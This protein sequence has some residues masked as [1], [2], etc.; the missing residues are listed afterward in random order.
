[1]NNYYFL[2]LYKL[3]EITPHSAVPAPCSVYS[4]ENPTPDALPDMDHDPDPLQNK[5]PAKTWMFFK[6]LSAYVNKPIYF[7]GSVRRFD[8][9]P[10]KSDIDIDIF[11]DNLNSTRVQ[12]MHFLK[13]KKKFKKI[14]WRLPSSNKVAHGFKI[15][16]ENPRDKIITEISVYEEKMKRYILDEHKLQSSLPGFIYFL[17][18]LVKILYYNMGLLS[19]EQYKKVKAFFLHTA[20]AKPAGD[21]VIIREYK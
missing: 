15:Y 7:F 21:F 5:L 1:M 3:H 11:T 12:L 4:Y 18:Y 8:F 17:L 2:P 14:I 9:I 19:K 16:Y 20:V 10:E 13:P 6:A